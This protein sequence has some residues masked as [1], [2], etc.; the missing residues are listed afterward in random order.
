MTKVVIAKVNSIFGIKGE[1]K[2]V[3][4][5]DNPLNIEAYALF[6][7]NDEPLKVK[8]TNKNKTIIGTSSGNPIIIAK[9]EGINNR[10]DAEKLRGRE[11]FVNREDMD[12]LEDDEFYYI[13]LVGLDVLNM[14]STKIGKIM[15]VLD[16]GAGGIVEVKFD[17]DQK[18][19]SYAFRDQFFPEVNIKEGY[20]SFNAPAEVVIEKEKGE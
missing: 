13:D 11:I 7:K 9:I 1:V 14:E 10:N 6:D 8:I 4:Y 3:V 2:L 5:S 19:E 16:H 20:V 17:A 15:N 12:S 18:I